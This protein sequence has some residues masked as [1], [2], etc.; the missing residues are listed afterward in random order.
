MVA[1]HELSKRL[2]RR[3]KIVLIE[4]RKTHLYQ[5]ALLWSAL[6]S[7]KISDAQMSYDSFAKKRIEVINAEILHIDPENKIV[8]TSQ[9]DIDF[10]SALIALGAEFNHEKIPG[11]KEFGQSF[12]TTEGAEKVYDAISGFWH[13][14]QG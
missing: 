7:Q 6:G 1:V 11:L 5:P 3:H 12:Y 8:K 4:K 13:K 14:L 9:G 2:M 10:D